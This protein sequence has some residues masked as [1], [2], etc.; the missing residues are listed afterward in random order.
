MPR[1][2]ARFCAAGQASPA[3]QRTLMPS[4]GSI[5]LSA[6]SGTPSGLN[7]G[8]SPLGQQRLTKWG[9]G[10]PTYAHSGSRQTRLESASGTGQSWAKT[11]VCGTRRPAT[12]THTTSLPALTLIL[13]QFVRVPWANRVRADARSSEHRQRERVQQQ[14]RRAAAAWSPASHSTV[15]CAPHAPQQRTVVATQ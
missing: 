15:A 13:T 4:M 1:A 9:L 11:R 7:T 14:A 8:F 6:H 2:L 3:G 5:A 10:R 12:Q